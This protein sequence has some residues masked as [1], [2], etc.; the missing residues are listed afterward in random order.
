MKKS[1]YIPAKRKK[2]LVLIN[3]ASGKGK[4]SKIWTEVASMTADTDTEFE[5]QLTKRAGHSKEILHDLDLDQYGGVVTV[6][7][8]GGLYDIINGLYSRQDWKEVHDKF[9]IG[10]VPG[11]SGHAMHCS[12]LF[13]QK[14]RFDQE[15]VVSAL[16]IGRGNLMTYDYIECSNK[17]SKFVSLFGVA[18]GVVPEVDVGSEFMRFLGPNR[19]RLLG[20]WRLIYPRFHQG[21][22]YYRPHSDDDD[23]SL[24]GIDDPVPTSWKS[25]E[26]PFL[27]VYACKQPWLDYEMFFC[28]DAKPDD[29]IIWL[30]IIMGTINRKDSIYWLLNGESSG[31]LKSQG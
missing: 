26:G 4:A 27:N 16:N 2:I 22:V 11:G 30:V 25:I 23:G 19:G 21:T 13:H 3:P 14:E 8:D 17:T 5:V 1:S 28:P 7:R 20:L 24:P 12:L 9:P 6:S 29:G 10:L 31:H 18:W 15:Y